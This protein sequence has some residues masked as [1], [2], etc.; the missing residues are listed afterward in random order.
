MK[1]WIPGILMAFAWLTLLLAGP[2][3]LF[4]LVMA[5]VAALCGYEFIKMSGGGDYGLA[6]RGYLIAA[7]I[8][9][10]LFAGDLSPLW[11]PADGLFLSFFLIS[12]YFIRRYTHFTN[13]YERLTRLAFGALYIGFLASYLVA[14]RYLP[15]GGRWLVVLTAV[16]AGS[17]T[18][19]YLFGKAFGRHKL[20]PGISPNKT[21]EGAL[22][23]LFCGIAMAL[24]VAALLIERPNFSFLLLA[25]TVLTG[26]GVLGDLVES[27]IKRGSGVKD[28]GTILAGHGGVLD[29]VDSLLLAGP[30]FYYM[31]ILT[32]CA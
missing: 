23:G 32:G 28:S 30:V 10:V 16:T 24:L 14:L 7:F 5:G 18:G 2:P 9:P 25:A 8:L 1:R 26:V 19:A 13:S 15:D 3:S 11:G 12:L 6:G 27:I 29:R 20:C 21:V 17:A 22:G 4:F 31:L